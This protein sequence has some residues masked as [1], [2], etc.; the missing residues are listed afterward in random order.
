M[1]L[2]RLIGEL[3]LGFFILWWTW[4]LFNKKAK[5]HAAWRGRAWGMRLAL[6]AAIVLTLQLERLSGLAGW[7]AAHG[8]LV[9]R[10]TRFWQWSGLALCAAGFLFALWARVHLRG[11]WGIPMSLRQGHELVTSG[12]YAHVRHPIYSGLMLAGLGTVLVLGVAWLPAVVLA[13]LFFVFSAR[14]EERMLC[15]Q[16]PHTYPAYQARTRMLIPFVI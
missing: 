12:P 16:F 7:L 4:A 10:P 14:T 11:N 1:T 8:G 13:G 2:R 15:A 3:W 5:R 9:P 6:I